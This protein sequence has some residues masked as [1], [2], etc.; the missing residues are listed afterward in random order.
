LHDIDARD[1]R[2][3]RVDLDDDGED[4]VVFFCPECSVR[5]FGDFELDPRG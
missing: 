3:H 1:W 2:A 4:E 5:E